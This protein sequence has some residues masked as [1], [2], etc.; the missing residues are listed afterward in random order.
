MLG[1]KDLRSIND[2]I[3]KEFD[4]VINDLP[5]LLKNSSK[6][7][8][9]ICFMFINTTDAIKE[10][11][12]NMIS[13]NNYYAI[14]ILYRALL[15]HFFRFMYYFFNQ[16]TTS[17]TDIYSHKFRTVLDF[18]DKMLILKSKNHLSKLNSQEIKTLTQ[19]KEG[20]YNSDS[21]YKNYE[22]NELEKITKELTIKNIISLIEKNILKVNPILDDF[23]RQKIV[24][25]S[26][27]SSYVHGG[28]FAHQE[29]IAFEFDS[30]KIKK[31]T[32]IYGLALQT[33]AFIKMNSL[34]ILSEK[35]PEYLNHYFKISTSIFKMVENP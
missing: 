14:N 2:E 6:Y 8:S 20:L 12:F 7:T 17:D 18:N 13:S 28:I 25:Y 29:F 16:I 30:D 32:V 11:I 26:K 5:D 4:I 27:L 10:S 1:L 15:E 19:I 21:N 23:L 24:H 9:E 3:S 33:T 31:L 35:N 22:L 34:L